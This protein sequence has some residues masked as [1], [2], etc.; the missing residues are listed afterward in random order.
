MLMAHA[1]FYHEFMVTVARENI[2][3][4]CGCL[5]SHIIYCKNHLRVKFAS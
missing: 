4:A 1:C 5:I 3:D 2:L